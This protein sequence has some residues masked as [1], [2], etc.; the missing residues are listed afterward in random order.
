MDRNRGTKRRRRILNLWSHTQAQNAL[1]YIAS[2]MSSLREHKLEAERLQL[3]AR[4]LANKPGRPDRTALIAHE[5]VLR[6]AATAE[7]NFAQAMQ[8]LE[9]LDIYC[10]DPIAG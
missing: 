10:L 5:E 7:D 9:K 2:V 8:E 1:P 6:E 3:A 4:R